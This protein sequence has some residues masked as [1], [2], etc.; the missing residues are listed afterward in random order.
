MNRHH[1]HRSITGSL[2]DFQ[3]CQ[4]IAQRARSAIPRVIKLLYRP[5]NITQT[6]APK[7]GQAFPKGLNQSLDHHREAFLASFIQQVL[8]RR[9]FYILEAMLNH[10]VDR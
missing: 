4:P 10:G 5:Q 1:L 3:S 2:T 7:F 8:P 6:S 9:S